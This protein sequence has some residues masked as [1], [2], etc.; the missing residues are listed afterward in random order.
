MKTENSTNW[1]E[2]T[3]NPFKAFSNLVSCLRSGN[4]AWIEKQENGKQSYPLVEDNPDLSKMKYWKCDSQL[5]ARDWENNQQEILD[6]D[7]LLPMAKT[8]MTEYTV[9]YGSQEEYDAYLQTGV[10]KFN[11]I[12]KQFFVKYDDLLKIRKEEGIEMDSSTRFYPMVSPIERYKRVLKTKR[13]VYVI[14]MDYEDKK[15]LPIW[16]KIINV[17]TYPFRFIPKQ[18]VLRMDDYTNYTF[19]I[20]DVCNGYSVEFQIPKKFSFK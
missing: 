6:D 15:P 5:F 19:R 17:V 20:G 11:G 7:K 4:N 3:L 9:L 16:L 1:S 12:G 2:A 8:L 18:S 10:A 13:K 14:V